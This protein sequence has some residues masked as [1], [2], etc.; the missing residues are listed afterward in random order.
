MKSCILNIAEHQK[1]SCVDEFVCCY[2][3]KIHKYFSIFVIYFRSC[4]NYVVDV[5]DSVFNRT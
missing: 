5:L 4:L 1:N 2:D 3:P